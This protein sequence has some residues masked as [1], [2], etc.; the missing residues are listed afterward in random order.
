MRTEIKNVLKSFYKTVG[1]DILVGV[2]LIAGAWT[3]SSGLLLL[4]GDYY[5]HVFPPKPS[6]I[7]DMTFWVIEGMFFIYLAIETRKYRKIKV[8]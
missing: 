5:N 4:Y 1:I 2:F 3:I 6:Q 8:G 7:G